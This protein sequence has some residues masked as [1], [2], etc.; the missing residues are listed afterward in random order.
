MNYFGLDAPP[1]SIVPDHKGLF[2]SES[3]REAVAH[4]LYAVKQSG[5]FVQLTGE[6]GTGKTTVSRYI[7]SNLPENVDVALLLNPRINELEMLQTI[8]DEL[9]VSYPSTATYKELIDLLNGYLLDSHA[10]GRHT[11]LMIDEAQNLSREVLEQIRLLTNLETSTDKLLQ[12]ILIGQPELVRTLQRHDLRQLSQ[13]IVGRFKLLP[14]SLRETKEYIEHRLQIH[15]SEQPLFTGPAIR[16][17]H[18]L[19]EGIPRLINVL[20]DRAL[21]G[22]YARDKRKVD[23]NTVKSAATEV[24]NLQKRGIGL[25][26]WFSWG[27]LGLILMAGVGFGASHLPGVWSAIKYQNSQHSQNKMSESAS[28]ESDIREPAESDKSALKEEL[29]TPELSNT[30]DNLDG[31]LNGAE[32]QDPVNPPLQ[33]K[34]D[35]ATNTEVSQTEDLQSNDESGFDL[36]YRLGVPLK[37]P[38]E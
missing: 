16:K 23:L 2:M 9:S 1:F 14:L 22:A 25:W 3:H 19:T 33:V 28:S 32:N 38:R 30:N 8:C 26:K 21:M 17:I 36:K 20:C 11:V 10:R 35:V 13:R 29:N 7:L 4:L 27:V 6:V 18:K 34:T 5:G 31:T 12:I 15:G 37:L 24:L